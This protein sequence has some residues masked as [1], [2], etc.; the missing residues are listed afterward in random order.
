MICS[1]LHR[2]FD[3]RMCVFKICIQTQEPLWCEDIRFNLLFQ[4]LLTLYSFR[5]IKYIY[6]P[7]PVVFWSVCRRHRSVGVFYISWKVAS[8]LNI[9]Q[10]LLGRCKI[11]K[12]YEMQIKIG[13]RSR[14]KGWTTLGKSW[15]TWEGLRH[16]M[17]VLHSTIP[18]KP[19]SITMKRFFLLLHR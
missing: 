2:Q 1:E 9:K 13:R 7:E 18:I 14:R 8:L 19:P 15:F 11:V 6:E 12:K 17:L 16:I 3:F 4:S 5:M 10:G